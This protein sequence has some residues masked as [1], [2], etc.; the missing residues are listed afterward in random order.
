MLTDLRDLHIKCLHGFSTY[1][2][3]IILL[4]MQNSIRI[5][6]SMW[7]RLSVLRGSRQLLDKVIFQKRQ[8]DV[9]RFISLTNYDLKGKVLSFGAYSCLLRTLTL[10]KYQAYKRKIRWIA[11]ES[12]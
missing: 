11:I 2:Y 4:Q 5:R 9:V 3:L 12:Y 1:L 10:A 8:S 6:N 7:S